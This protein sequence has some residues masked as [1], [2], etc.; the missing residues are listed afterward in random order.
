MATF[1]ESR[2]K[3]ESTPAVEDMVITDDNEPK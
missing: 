2:Q 3:T 1:N